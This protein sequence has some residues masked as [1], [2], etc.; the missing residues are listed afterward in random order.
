MATGQVVD[1]HWL[2]VLVSNKNNEVNM[3]ICFL[4]AKINHVSINYTEFYLF[5]NIFSCNCS[6]PTAEESPLNST[7]VVNILF[8][9]GTYV[10]N[11]SY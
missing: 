5:T 10:R 11:Y 8:F 6:I 2:Y 4:P 9:V 7:L 1:S 3:C